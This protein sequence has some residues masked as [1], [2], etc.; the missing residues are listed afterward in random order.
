MQA[1]KAS[2][3]LK[4]IFRIEKNFIPTN[5]IL[6]PGGLKLTMTILKILL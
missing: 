4:G 5:T 1:N 6:I 2:K 3:G